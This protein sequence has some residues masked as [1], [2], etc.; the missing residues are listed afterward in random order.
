M[1]NRT[2]IIKQPDKISFFND[3]YKLQKKYQDALILGKSKKNFIWLGEHQLCYTLGTGSNMG[4]LLFSLNEQDVFKIDRGG[5][6]TCHMPG[7]LVTYLVLDL[8]DFNKDLNWYLRKIE[9]I[10]VKVLSI[11][12]IN[13]S[14]KDGFTGVWIGERKIASIG[15]GCK[16]WVTI[17]GFSINVN[18]KLEN[19]DRI[20][21]CGI[22]DCLMANM[23]DYNENLDIKE[24]KKIV[25]KIIQEEFNFN[26]V[27]E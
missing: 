17:H 10:I 26:V 2:A 23:S 18:C 19:F 16:R 4:N 7:Q 11:F 27:S 21:P 6:V 14:T 15:I 3:V 12:D 8:N 9:E 13:C 1:I 5:E 25:K 20:V 24:V 22:K